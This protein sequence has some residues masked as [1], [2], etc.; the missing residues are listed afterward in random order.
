MNGYDQIIA[1]N[2]ALKKEN[3]AMNSPTRGSS[4]CPCNKTT[5][6]DTSAASGST[7]HHQTLYNLGTK[8]RQCPEGP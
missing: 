3:A 4:S 1:E 8:S 2:N 6:T 5:T 7:N